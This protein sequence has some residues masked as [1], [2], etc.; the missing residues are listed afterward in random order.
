MQESVVPLESV[1]VQG[2]VVLQESV[3]V[4][5]SLAASGLPGTFSAI[6]RFCG[7][8]GMVGFIHWR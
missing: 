4:L 3:A 2:S 6:V 7:Q 8:N 1:A 5:E